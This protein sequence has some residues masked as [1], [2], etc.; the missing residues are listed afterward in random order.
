MAR[1]RTNV[2]DQKVERLKGYRS[3]KLVESN[4]NLRKSFLVYI[5]EIEEK[6]YPFDEKLRHE[7]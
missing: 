7:A 6:F 3:S 1:E 2:D 4:E 5:D